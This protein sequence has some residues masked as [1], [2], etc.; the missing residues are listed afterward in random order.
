MFE[1]GGVQGCVGTLLSQVTKGRKLHTASIPGFVDRFQTT[2]KR[3]PL[4]WRKS[5]RIRRGNGGR[6][7]V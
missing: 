5:K 6:G 3:D 7:S 4:F 2:V 1:R